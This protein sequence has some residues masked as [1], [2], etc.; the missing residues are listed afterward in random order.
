M[1]KLTAIQKQTRLEMAEGRRAAK[2]SGKELK[3]R[4]KKM[5]AERAETKRVL[6]QNGAK[7]DLAPF[8]PREDVDPNVTLPRQVRMQTA[9]ANAYYRPDDPTAGTIL[10]IKKALADLGN[11]ADLLDDLYPIGNS[12]SLNK[13]A[14]DILLPF[15]NRDVVRTVTLSP[16]TR[17]QLEQAIYEALV[18]ACTGQK[19]RPMI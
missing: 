5:T 2:K 16:K 9:I 6:K 4:I 1:A 15:C 18:E 19:I 12:R 7:E 3:D 14:K 13:W 11:V 10:R 17:E 8:L